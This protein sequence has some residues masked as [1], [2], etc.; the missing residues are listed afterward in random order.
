MLDDIIYESYEILI[1]YQWA[2]MRR[3]ERDGVD[4]HRSKKQKIIEQ[5]DKVLQQEQINKI[6]VFLK[7]LEDLYNFPDED[8]DVKKQRSAIRRALRRHSLGFL[9]LEN[10]TPGMVDALIDILS[11]KTTTVGT[12]PIKELL[13]AAVNTINRVYRK[14]NPFDSKHRLLNRSDIMWMY[15]VDLD[16]DIK[17]IFLRKADNKH[18]LVDIEMQKYN[19][20][21]VKKSLKAAPKNMENTAEPETVACPT[22]EAQNQSD[23][24]IDLEKA[25]EGSKDSNE[26]LD[27]EDVP[28][29]AL[30][31][32]GRHCKPALLSED[33]IENLVQYYKALLEKTSSRELSKA[34]EKLHGVML[35]NII[36]YANNHENRGSRENIINCI[37]SYY[38]I[39]QAK[40]ITQLII[41]NQNSKAKWLILRHQFDVTSSSEPL[42]AALKQG[43]T[44]MVEFLL[45]HGS[46][47]TKWDLDDSFTAPDNIMR[48]LQTSFPR[49]FSFDHK[50]DLFSMPRKA[51]ETRHNIAALREGPRDKITRYIWANTLLQHHV[52]EFAAQYLCMLWYQFT[53]QSQSLYLF[54]RINTAQSPEVLRNLEYIKHGEV[55]YNIKYDLND[56]LYIQ[57]LLTQYIHSKHQDALGLELS[58]VKHSGL[59]DTYLVTLRSTKPEIQG[60]IECLELRENRSSTAQIKKSEMM[61]SIGS[62]EDVHIAIRRM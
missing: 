36:R 12:D 17:T 40:I 25:M 7:I 6:G 32:I 56:I 5:V 60:L 11:E 58:I 59:L 49:T 1:Y 43:N 52:D 33:P 2:V 27:D 45:N 13:K 48:L 39:L 35:V 53:S 14:L 8:R 15:G 62:T 16:D 18:D 23:A 21:L 24:E 37:S 42:I 41:D 3:K 19:K 44:E 31:F 4:K 22:D 55:L 50:S 51:L 20:K 30:F 29:E 47:I 61:E 54:N 28:D 9:D 10:V 38:C 46:G 26:R 57:N 34:I